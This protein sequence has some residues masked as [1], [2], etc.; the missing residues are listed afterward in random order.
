MKVGKEKVSPALSSPKAEVVS[1]PMNEPKPVEGV[2]TYRQPAQD[3]CQAIS[4]ESSPKSV[5][6]VT[7]VHTM[8]T[9]R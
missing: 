5:P 6:V 1:P 9:R 8:E 2:D 7:P 4:S 3:S